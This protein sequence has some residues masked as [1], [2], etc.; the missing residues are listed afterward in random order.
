M[1]ISS[2]EAKRSTPRRRFTPEFTLTGS[3]VRL[4]GTGT[5]R[6]HRYVT[7]VMVAGGILPRGTWG[8]RKLTAHRCPIPHARRAGHCAADGRYGDGDFA[9]YRNVLDADTCRVI[10]PSWLEGGRRRRKKRRRR[11]RTTGKGNPTCN[12]S[13]P[14]LPKGP[15]GMVSCVLSYTER[16]KRLMQWS[17]RLMTAATNDGC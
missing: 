6:V 16:R 11:T 15:K 10:G 2:S 9:P 3:S 17:P 12:R 14:A 8:M 1:V 13:C 7:F 4:R 5:L